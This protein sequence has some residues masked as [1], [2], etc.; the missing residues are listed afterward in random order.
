MVAAGA[1]DTV[2]LKSDGTVVA[3]ENNYR[4]PCNVQ[5]WDLNERPWTTETA[6]NFW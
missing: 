6:S 4:A 5:G 3:M 1:A 2:G